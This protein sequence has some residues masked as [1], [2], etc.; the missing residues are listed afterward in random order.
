M[1]GWVGDG[2]DG[3]AE[4]YLA[5][6]PVRPEP[7][8]MRN[9]VANLGGDR[10]EV[11][12]SGTASVVLT[13]EHVTIVDDAGDLIGPERRTSPEWVEVAR[14]RGRAV[15]AISEVPLD[16][17]ADTAALRA[18]ADAG[19]LAAVLLRIVDRS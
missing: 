16:P 12:V 14:G 13:G 1:S 10:F 11:I 9:L 6:W 3:G 2:P 8:A 18:E 19:R 7:E 17:A 5:L 15:L 4:A